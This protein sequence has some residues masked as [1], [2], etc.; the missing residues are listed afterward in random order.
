MVKKST[1]KKTEIGKP[2]VQVTKSGGSKNNIPTR[3]TPKYRNFFTSSSSS[4][5]STSSS[6]SDEYSV[7][8]SS[9]SSPLL[10]SDVKPSGVSK[11]AAQH[12]KKPAPATPESKEA[13]RV[14][15]TLRSPNVLT[16]S[17]SSSS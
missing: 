13:P 17:S 10:S 12:L 15:R 3:M 7:Y 4:S 2:T 9:S 6:G 1:A 16:S 5:S 14:S 8:S 11:P